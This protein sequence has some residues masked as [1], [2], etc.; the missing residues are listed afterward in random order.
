[1]KS[2]KRQDPRPPAASV[3]ELLVRASETAQANLSQAIND[4]AAAEVL[5]NIIKQARAPIRLY[6]RRV[7]EMFAYVTVSLGVVQL[8]KQED[9]GDLILAD[10]LNVVVPDFRVLLA[11][12]KQ[13]FIEVKNCYARSPSHAKIFKLN[14]LQALQRYGALFSSAV[15]IA[16]YWSAWRLWTLHSV[17]SAISGVRNDRLRLSLLRALPRS[18]MRILGDATLATEYP[19]T[20]RLVVSGTRLSTNGSESQHA[21][22][23]DDVEMA[24]QG[25]PIKV[26]RDKDIAFGLMMHGK[27]FDSEPDI[28]MQGD[29]I[30][31][32]E[33]TFAPEE[34]D[35]TV[36]F[37]II[38]TLS[39]LASSQFNDLTLYGDVIRRLRPSQLPAPPYPNLTEE[40]FGE[41]LPL[42]RFVQQAQTEW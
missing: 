36:P 21:I 16:V 17:E 18:E 35:P 40:Y 5:A 32:V 10:D 11:D 22:R 31:A 9:A 4:P 38:S 8:I 15:Y 13:I 20:L 41:D 37:S 26:E 19:L 28:V 12:G 39:T 33:F 7:E 29:T 34:P 25:R 6:G 24:V 23:I 27:W 1:M 42:W 14:Y 3:L 2:F 30:S